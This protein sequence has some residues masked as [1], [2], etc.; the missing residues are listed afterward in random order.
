MRRLKYELHREGVE[1]GKQRSYRDICDIYE[2]RREGKKEYLFLAE[3][4]K[5][6]DGGNRMG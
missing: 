5:N 4:E 2:G 6:R 1:A 3:H